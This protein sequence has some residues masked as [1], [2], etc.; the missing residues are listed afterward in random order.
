MQLVSGRDHAGGVDT[1]PTALRRTDRVRTTRRRVRINARVSCNDAYNADRLGIYVRP[2][3]AFVACR[4]EAAEHAAGIA[5]CL[6]CDHDDGCASANRRQYTDSDAQRRSDDLAPDSDDV[7]PDSDAHGREPLWG[8]AEPVRLQ[9]LRWVIHLR[10][11]GRCVQ[12][13]Q[14]HR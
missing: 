14:L 5:R 2:C 6:A 7:A 8:S 13:L 4:L 11:S 12:L 10:A 3:L 1:I 9:L